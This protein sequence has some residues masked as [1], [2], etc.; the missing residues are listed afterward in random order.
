MTLGEHLTMTASTNMFYIGIDYKNK[1]NMKAPASNINIKI[2]HLFSKQRL[3]GVCLI[4]VEREILV[5][6]TQTCS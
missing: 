4:I 6:L 1:I 3:L 5:D 2:H